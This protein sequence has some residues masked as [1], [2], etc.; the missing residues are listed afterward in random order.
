MSYVYEYG[1]T[2]ELLG[3]FVGCIEPLEDLVEMLCLLPE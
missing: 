2:C 1:V 3:G